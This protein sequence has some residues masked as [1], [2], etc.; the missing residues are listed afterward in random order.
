VV[1]VTGVN[2]SGTA[3]GLSVATSVVSE[4]PEPPVSVVP[5]VSGVAAEGQTLSVVPGAWGGFPAPEL[6]YQWLRCDQTGGGCVPIVG[7]TAS[8]YV[9]S[10][11]DVGGTL[12]VSATGTNTSGTATSS[13]LQTSVI[14][15]LSE[16]PV[17]SIPTV[18]GV[19]AEGQAL[20]AVPGAWG[21]Y[22]APELSYQWSRCDQLGGCISIPGATSSTYVLDAA[23][24][25]EI[26]EVSVTGVNP[27]GTAVSASGA[28]AVVVGPPVPGGSPSVAG[29][30]AEGEVLTAEPGVWGGYPAPE[31]SYQWLR[32]DQLGGG[33]APISGATASIYVPGVADVGGTL[34]LSVTGVNASGTAA[35]A[36]DVGSMVSG[37]PSSAVPVISG[38]AVEGHTL[39]ASP[40]AWGGYPTPMLSYQWFRCDQIESVCS[41]IQGATGSMYSL[42]EADLGETLE[43]S[44]TGTNPSGTATSSSAR[45]VV[46]GQLG[47]PPV[48]VVPV[49]SGLA[50]E[51]QVLSVVSGVWGG[52]PAPELAY[53]WLRCDQAGGGCVPIVGA[54]ASG[55]VLSA[56]DVGGT[57]RVSATGTNTSGTTSATSSASPAV[58][59]APGPLTPVLDSFSRANNT[60]PPS[61][62]WTHAGCLNSTAKSNLYVLGNQAT[63]ASGT[64]T[65]FWNANSFGSNSEAFV[66]VASTPTA[67]GDF[68]ALGLRAQN[69]ASTSM[70]AYQGFYV[71]GTATPD[72][73]KIVL[74]T[75]GTSDTALVS[76][77]A[78]PR[79]AAGDR[80]LFRAIGNTLELWVYDGGAWL[81]VL[82]TRSTAIPSAG[83]ATLTARNSVVRL[84]DFGGGTLP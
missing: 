78:G 15:G 83:Y 8:G 58:I 40:G 56:A 12:R 18:A 70:S 75:N 66:T 27:S 74:R 32:C 68:V 10:A 3:V 29:V 82:S 55:Y 62:S 64:D 80:L 51:G 23:D 79:L 37:P 22:P 61:G 81:K 31:L 69:P 5:V 19:A 2:S 49:V 9:L 21:G 34:Q 7:A 20:I 71:H 6:S 39:S 76:T 44:V 72:E 30:A 84:D 13:S 43:V 73:Y 28:S 41:P 65:D 52:F 54:T 47:E 14:N 48:S 11:A 46:I 25:G 4:P 42:G 53:Q 45:T 67:N 63:G 77:T 16:S 33:C 35:S 1:R 60:G 50:V 24:V 38:E 26:L 57:L 59:S 17:P 36:S